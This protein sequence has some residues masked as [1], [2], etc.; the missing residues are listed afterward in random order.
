[1]TLSKNKFSHLFKVTVHG[2]CCVIAKDPETQTSRTGM[3]KGHQVCSQR[4]ATFRKMET[5]TSVW[6]KSHD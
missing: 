6:G 2:Q 4:Q 3:K 1:M 5:L